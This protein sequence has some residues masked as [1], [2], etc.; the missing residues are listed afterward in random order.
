MDPVLRAALT[1]W[2]LRIEIILVLALAGAFYSL[3]WIRLKKRAKYAGELGH[4]QASALWRPIAYLSGLVVLG[5]A[6]M[7]PIDVLASQL[8]TMHMIQHVL[9]MM[10]VP[11]LLLL[12]NPL[13]FLL[14]GL[15]KNARLKTG[16]LLSSRSRFRA[17]LRRTTGP[18]ITWLLFVIV[19]W[20]WHD[21]NAYNLALQSAFIHDV[22]HLTFFGVSML[23]WWHIIGAG[24]RIHR[25]L[26]HLARFGYALAAIPPNMV[27]GMAIVFATDPI[28]TYYEAMPRLWGISI[29][30]DQRIAGVIMWVFGSMMFIVAALI[31]IGRWLQIEERKPP[32]PQSAWAS[33]E[34]LAAPGINE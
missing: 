3:G 5:I 1:S 29:I 18:G 20:G 26:S 23:Y 7:S 10:I 11:P 31:L 15:P 4:W 27:A 32:L 12:A 21:P 34:A 24:P 33:D 25:P 13:P 2:D 16:S 6:L 17:F 14:W 22:E 8:F 9:L 30:Q 19:Y 28:Y